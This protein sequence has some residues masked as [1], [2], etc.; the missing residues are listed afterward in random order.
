M[1]THSV[2]AA[3]RTCISASLAATALVPAIFIA[4]TALA[5]DA[6]DSRALE[7][8]IVTGSRI[9][10]PNLETISPVTIVSA[11]D[12]QQQGTIRVEDM[13]NKLP[14]IFAGQASSLSNGADGTATVDL[15]GLGA[16]RTLV[17]INGRRMMPGEPGTTGSLAADINAIPAN[18]IKRVEVLTGGASAT[19]GADA[20]AGVVNFIMDTDFTG[21]KIDA[22]HSFYQHNNSNS[23][24]RS[25]LASRRAEGLSGYDAPSSNV[26]DG[27]AWDLTA[28]MGTN[29]ADGSGHLTGY[30]GYRTQKAV[31]QNNRDFSACTIQNKN[32]TD[33]QCG[34]SATSY[35]G[36][37]FLYDTTTSGITS[38]A[39]QFAPGRGLVPG[40]NRYNFAPTNY[41][42]RPDTRYTGGLFAN[43]DM[44]DSI[45]P[46]MEFMFMDDRTVAQIAP[47]GDFGNTLMINCDNPLMSAA[48]RAIICDNINLITGFLGNFPLVDSTNDL[49]PGAP[50]MT[51]YDASGATYNKAFFQPLRRNVEGGPRRA[52][53]QHT[54][55]RSLIGAKG[56]LSSA[57]S[58]DAYYQFGRTVYAQTYENEFSVV[59]LNRALDVVAGPGGVPT[60]RSAMD[61]TDP[62]CVPYDI[63]SGEGVSQAAVNYVSAVGFQRGNIDQHIASGA[64]TGKLGQY[65]AKTPWSESGLAVALGAEWRR[66]SLEF[67]ADQAFQTGDLT[68][69]GAP[70]LPISGNI[71]VQE[72]FSEAQLPVITQGAV[73]NLTLNAGYRYS[74]YDTSGGGDYSTNT[75]K[76]GVEFA[77]IHQVR[78][79]AGYNRAVRSPNIQELF[80]PRYVGLDGSSDP[81]AGN[82]LTAA[83]VG[84]LAQGLQIGQSVAGNPAGQYNGLLGGTPTL[85]PEEATTKS[86]G[87]ILQPEFLPRFSM[88]IDYY[89]IK[90]DK[91]IQSF[92]ADA[93][94]NTCTDDPTSSACSLI[95]RNPVTGSLWLTPDGYITDLQSNI[96]GVKTKGVDF[97][98]AY[99]L[100]A[101]RIGRLSFNLIGTL[102][103][104][105]TV[106]NGISA[107][108][109]CVG[110][111]GTTCSNLLTP[112]APTPRWRHNA[113]V[114]LT[115]PDGF[116]A[117]LQWRY[118]GPVKVDYTS[119]NSTLQGNYDSFGSQLAGQHWFDLTG[120]YTFAEKYTVRLGINNILDRTPPLVSS[121]RSNGTRNQCPTGP[122]NGNTYPAVYDA[123]GRYV[124]LGV[125]LD[126]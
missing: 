115:R 7:E 100:D 22:Q 75:Y 5:A 79:R 43:Y 19:Y 111:Y 86:I 40:L 51:F 94:I 69:Q 15:R 55:Y 71:K 25:L 110:L 12:I 13:L 34:G 125:S 87:V 50:P 57:W 3:V 77:P 1:K 26:T 76:F 52:D 30:I 85:R 9:A 72:L 95:H 116:G 59:R 108:Y 53:L 4:N 122:C 96:G 2:R 49:N 38:T 28:T 114:T 118:F 78:F 33:L 60:C 83:D 101:G 106:D 74:K 31:T 119:D 112:S 21:L 24:V 68:G 97:N 41:F 89:D 90:V 67:N 62:T 23:R 20:V 61:G 14:Q 70:T 42:Q 107:P 39:Y 44:S 18:L 121:G 73:D 81:C 123:L 91:A 113:R 47:S 36:N 102:L 82:P 11:E 56:D 45:K 124:F 48:Q 99:S 63:L 6:D 104:D 80:A 35:P 16:A 84:C 27:Q 46:Y 66:D 103:T 109:D 92:G 88:T 117:S 105:F 54:S 93:I 58:Y 65:G 32:A 29:F 126:L 8:V 120:W 64:V 98:A 37:V 10:Q 17:L